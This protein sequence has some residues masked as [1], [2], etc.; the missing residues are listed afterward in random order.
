MDDARNA[1]NRQTR[2]MPITEVKRT[3]AR[4]VDDVQQGNARVLIEKAGAPAA[5]MVSV[6]DLARLTRLDQEK[7]ERRRAVEVIGAAFRDV[8]LE[9]IEAQLARIAAEGPQ[10]ADEEP[11][12]K[13]A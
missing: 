3:L 2:T 7:A 13:L 1:E 11:T 9:E 12:R 6:D 4:L 8:P 5:A 10:V